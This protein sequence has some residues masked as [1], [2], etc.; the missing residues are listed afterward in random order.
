MNKKGFLFI[1]L[2][3]PLLA[4]AQGINGA[5]KGLLEAG[6]DKLNIVFHINADKSVTMDSPDQGTMRIP[7]EVKCLRKDT[8][9]VELPNL[10]AKY[11]GKLVDD[12][13]HGTFSQVGYSFPLNLK[14]GDVKI[15]RPQTPQPPFEYTT[16]E[17]AFQNKGVDSKTGQ[18]TDGGEAWFG[19]TLTYPKNFK[20]GIPVVLMVT[21][22]GQQNRDEEI[23]GH[24]P[25]LVIAD[26]LARHG[27]ASLRYDDRGVGKSTGDPAKV[28]LH[29]NTLDAQ[30]GI[31]Y[32]KTLK[33]FGKIGVLGHSEGGLIGYILAANNN[34]DF[35]VSLAGPVLPGDSVLILQN[36]D[37][38]KVMGL[39]KE[40]IEK[41]STAITRVFQYKM[42]E[43]N[44]GSASTPDSIVTMITADIDL[45][46]NL[47][48]NL[49]EAIKMIDSPWLTSYLKYNPAADVNKIKCPVMI[50]NGE[51]D[52]QL[53]STVN[54]QTA[55]KIF[56]KAAKAK[57][58]F[59][60]YPGLNHFFQ[61]SKTD[62]PT[63]YAKIETTISE[64]VLSDITSWIGKITK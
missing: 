17:V 50:L 28:T 11:N 26:Y 32:L 52:K 51:N 43:Q 9:A 27:I 35:V 37:L 42:S 18:P 59:K 33:K 25:F 60:S 1:L 55:E 14:R 13:I 7:T 49:I 30:A 63:E 48:Q 57:S 58:L 40:N 16:Q 23:M 34:A 2:I 19:G 41:Y 64:D 61:P 39:D 21:G 36:R 8:L 3:I 15:N 10:G 47:R 56:S 54:L 31:E 12:E 4:N 44:I 22:S 62:S 29:S 24:K 6:P 45:L 38:L 20:P 53:N 5:W 46:P